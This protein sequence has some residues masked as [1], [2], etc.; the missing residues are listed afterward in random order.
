[1]LA[2]S[3]QIHPSP[4]SSP[5]NI[6]HRRTPWDLL[7]I[8]F[9]ENLPA[10]ARTSPRNSSSSARYVVYSPALVRVCGTTLQLLHRLYSSHCE[11]PV[12]VHVSQS[13]TAQPT[14]P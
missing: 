14:Y 7:N 10:A 5:H 8:A 3:R 1:M 13:A 4:T 12:A 11:I 9:P 2:I 6:I